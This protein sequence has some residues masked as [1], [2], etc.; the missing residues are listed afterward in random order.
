M[1]TSGWTKTIPFKVNIAGVVEI[2]GSS[3]YSRL[4]TPLRELIQNA[5]D[6]VQRRRHRDLGYLGRIDIVQDPERGALAI[7]DDGMGLSPDEAETY[8]GTLGLG[9]TGLL[10]KGAAPPGLAADAGDLVG[11]FGIG[12]FSAF[13]IADRIVVES[14]RVDA[15]EGVRWSAG[16]TTDI[17]LSSSTREKPG[18]TVT[19]ELKPAC[20]AFATDEQLVERAIVEFADFLPVPIHLNGANQRANV[21]QVAWFEPTPEPEQIELALERYFDETPLDVLPLHMESPV[22]I[23]GA[24]YVTPQRMPGF[25]G[26]PVVTVTVRRMVIS[27]R[28]QGLLPDWA[29]FLR[30]VLALDDCAPVASREDLVRDR[31]FAGARVQLERRLFE[32]FEALAD[33]DPPRL[34]A[35]IGWHRYTIAG[36]ALT[37]PRLRKLLRRA[38]KFITSRGALAFDEIIGHCE[39]DSASDGADRVVWY[40]ADH[41]Q[42]AWVNELFAQRERLCVHA[43]RSF[44]E[45]LLAAMVAD[46][47]EA[48]SERIDLRGV[49]PG[50]SDFARSL[51]DVKDLEPAPEAWVAFLAPI[52]PQAKVYTASFDPRRPVMAFLNERYELRKTFDELKKHSEVPVGFQRLIDRHFAGQE[53]PRDEVLLNRRHRLVERALAGSTATPLASVLRILVMNALVA[54]GSGLEREAYRQQ[55]EDLDWIA[56]ALW[57]RT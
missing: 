57:G 9:I 22:K 10:R 50:E 55:E 41:R 40:N 1:S 2:L 4:D 29:S 43:L 31:A 35:V 17:E 28:I 48:E 16:P 32:H 49:S 20:R 21:I 12:L 36:A 11:M 51:L 44:E 6:A 37:E 18:T 45:A 26:Q 24:L 19:L 54:A 30:G 5:H 15:P 27:R 52:C 33:V 42:E 53:Q 34:E 14:R 38:Y 7:S 25:S 39:A 8:L 56:E 47:A 46:V 23:A 13:L 3:L